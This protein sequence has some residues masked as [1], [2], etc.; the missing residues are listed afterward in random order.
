MVRVPDAGHGIAD[1][2]SNLIAKVGYV[3]GWFGRY[4]NGARGVS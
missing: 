3:L 4:R 1:R 2:P